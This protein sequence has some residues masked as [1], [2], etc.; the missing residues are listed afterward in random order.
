MRES[1]RT[2]EQEL[3][4]PLERPSE[5]RTRRTTVKEVLPAIDITYI[6]VTDFYFNLYRPENE[7]FQTSLYEIDRILKERAKS[8]GP[9]TR[10]SLE[11]AEIDE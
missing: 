6:D 5:P 9:Q 4:R 8:D 11:T 10:F 2:M 1:L 3:R 7:V